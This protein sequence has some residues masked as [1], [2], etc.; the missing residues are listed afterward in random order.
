MRFTQT[1]LMWIAIY[2]VTLKVVD[3]QE[4]KRPMDIGND[5]IQYPSEEIKRPTIRGDEMAKFQTRTVL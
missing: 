5:M 2:L 3:A 4:R 1:N